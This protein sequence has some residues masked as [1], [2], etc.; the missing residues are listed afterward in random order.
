MESATWCRT[1]AAASAA[2]RLRPE[3]SKNSSTALSSNDGELARS[4]TTCAPATASLTPSPVMVLTPLLGEAATTSWPPWRRMAT[5]FEPIRPV[6]PMT[7]IFMPYLL[8]C[9]MRGCVC[10]PRDEVA[11]GNVT[12]FRP[13]V[14]P[15]VRF[16]AAPLRQAVS[17]GATQ[18]WGERNTVSL[19]HPRYG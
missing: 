15:D 2:K 18:Y 10:S 1:P 12:I 11:H 17:S 4:I 16:K 7:T 9:R 6:P 14:N 5:V 8:V 3:V 19:V 13:R